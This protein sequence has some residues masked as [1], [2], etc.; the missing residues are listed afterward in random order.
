MIPETTA[1]G[2]VAGTMGRSGRAPRF[3]ETNRIGKRVFTGVI[4]WIALICEFHF[5]N[6][7]PVVFQD[8][9]D[10]RAR[11]PSP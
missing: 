11:Y 6:F 3:C 1:T 8:W 9:W 2:P 7:N 5:E 4:H 10:T